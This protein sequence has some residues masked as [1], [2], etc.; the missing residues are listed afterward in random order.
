MAGIRQVL[1]I[2]SAIYSVMMVII[3]ISFVKKNKAIPFVKTQG[4]GF[5][6]GCCGRNTLV[7]TC[8]YEQGAE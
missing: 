1:D 5:V 7:F 2:P 3:I 8:A 6:F 4:K